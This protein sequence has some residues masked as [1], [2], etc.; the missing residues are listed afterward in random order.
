M[1]TDRLERQSVARVTCSAYRVYFKQS[2]CISIINIGN[3][4]ISSPV[5]ESAFHL[6]SAQS[7]EY[8][9]VISRK[10][11]TVH[12]RFKL[13]HTYVSLRYSS[14]FCKQ[15]VALRVNMH[16]NS[17]GKNNIYTV[18]RKTRQDFLKGT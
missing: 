17:Y 3:G 1:T 4:R 15:E 9:L 10:Y 13:T 16:R 11:I 2:G 8:F 6:A 14:H 18:V 5:Q 7:L 12:S